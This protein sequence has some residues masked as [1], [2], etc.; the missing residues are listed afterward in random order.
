MNL[1]EI[2]QNI[3]ESEDFVISELKKMQ[4]LYGL[5]KEIRYA[6]SR[7]SETDTESVAEHIYGMHCLMDYFL[8]LEDEYSNWDQ[9]R[10]R[11]MIQYHDI[12]EIETGD[13]ISYLKSESDQAKERDAAELVINKLPFLTQEKI[14]IALNEYKLKETFESRFVKALDKIEPVFHLYNE[15]GKGMMLKLKTTK[16]QH[17]RVKFPHLQDFPVILRFSE[18]MTETFA[19]EGFY[20]SEA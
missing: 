4:T 18:V 2:K 5:K 1:S 8:P 16:D 19:K 15:E 11:I 17:D 12:D 7:A 9:A 13:V 14:R 20:H 3:F 6:Q 10:I